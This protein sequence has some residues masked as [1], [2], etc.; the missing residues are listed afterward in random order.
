M[1]L[2]NFLIAFGIVAHP[3]SFWLIG[4]FVLSFVVYYERIMFA[5]EA[6]LQQKFGS[7]F[8]DWSARTPAFVPRVTNW[9]SPVLPMDFIKACRQESAAIAVITVGF[10][11]LE[12]GSHLSIGG[13]E[14]VEPWWWVM[15]SVG[16]TLYVALRLL[17]RLYR[18][19]VESQDFSQEMSLIGASPR[20]PIAALQSVLECVESPVSLSTLQT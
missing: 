16:V 7:S 10:L 4:L 20:T 6:F 19:W 5:E 9:V 18:P 3:A 1:Y 14:T 2:G 13:I 12:M 17:K 11:L 15:T 8:T